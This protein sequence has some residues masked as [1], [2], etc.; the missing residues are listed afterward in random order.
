M[1]AWMLP[2][3]AS[4]LLMGCPP[5]LA[6]PAVDFTHPAGRGYTLTSVAPLP[7]KQPTTPDTI[8][9]QATYRG[10]PGRALP[11]G[12]VVTRFPHDEP[13]AIGSRARHV[14]PQTHPWVFV[15]VTASPV[16][17]HV[18]WS[19]WVHTSALGAGPPATEVPGTAQVLSGPAYLCAWPDGAPEPGDSCALEV[20]PSLPLDAL[21]CDGNYVQLQLWDPAGYY[22]SGY[23]RR[24]HFTLDPCPN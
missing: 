2:I 22:V 15:E 4:L 11:P 18:G 1:K 7:E 24:D 16:V 20:H 5:P 12:A 3:A 6:G 14:E 21:G 8:D 9:P 23:I 17:K 13:R 19:G 10:Q